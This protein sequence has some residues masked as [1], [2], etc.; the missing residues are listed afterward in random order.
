[1]MSDTSPSTADLN[2]APELAAMAIVDASL[3]VLRRAI[4]AHTLYME[5]PDEDEP[6]PDADIAHLLHAARN[7]LWTADDLHD[8]LRCYRRAVDRIVGRVTPSRVTDA[9][10]APAAR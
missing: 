2:V 9:F 6:H 5:D 7:V 4:E 10:A 1:M 3:S 8:R